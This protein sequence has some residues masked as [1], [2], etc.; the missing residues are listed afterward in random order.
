MTPSH[1]TEKKFEDHIEAHLLASG[2][3]KGKSGDYDREL[4]LIPAEVIAFVVATQPTEYEKLQKQYGDATDDN[5]CRRLAKEIGKRGTLDVLR[6]GFK[7]RGCSFRLSYFKPV[8]G[9]N[10]E[11]L[12]LYRQ[13]RFTVTRQPFYSTQNNNSIDV[14]LFLNGLPLITCELKNSLTGQFVE[15]AIKQYRKDRDP[16]EPFFKFKRCLVHFAVGNEKVAMTT[17]LAGNKT[18]F[19]PFNKDSENPVNPHGFRTHY[20]W[21]D[22]LQPDTLLDLL[23]NYLHVQTN[24]KK[25]Y[26]KSGKLEEKRSEALIFPRYHQ[27][28]VVRNLLAKVK[29]EGEGHSY[30]IQHSAGSGKSNSIAW[31]AH[32]LASLY[33]NQYDQQRLFDSIIVVTDRRVLDRQLQDTVKQFEQTTGV[34]V[35]IT[36]D[37]AA[38]RDAIEA[39]KDIIITTLQ[40]FGVISKTTSAHPGLRYAVIIDEAHSS[41]SGESAKHLNQTLNADLEH[42]EESDSVADEAT[43]EDK[44]LEEI[45]LRSKQQRHISYFAFTATPKNK[46]LELFGRKNFDGKPVAFH[47]YSMRQAIEE[48]FILDV[49]ENYT[50]FKRYFKLTKT[51]ASDK[52]FEKKKAI[53]LLTSYVDLQPHAIETKSRLMLDHFIDHTANAIEGRGRAMVVTRSRLHAVKYYL[54]FRKV[55]EEMNLSYKPLVAFSGEVIDPDTDARYTENGLNALPPKVG[56]P[57]ALKTPEFRILIAANKFQTGFDEPL[58]HTMYV[59]KKLGG[60]GAVQTL[61][62]LN[63]TMHGKDGCVVIDYVNEA[64]DILAGFQDYYQTTL[65]EDTTDPNKLYDLQQQ[66]VDF[67]L[68]LPKDVDAFATTFFDSKQPQEQLQPLLDAAR[69]LWRQ[70]EVDEREEFRGRLNQFSRLYGFLSQILTFEDVELEKFYVFCRLLARKLDRREGILP[71]EVLDAVDLDSFR[72][73]KTYEGT[74]DLRPED[75]ELP[76]IG[77]GSSGVN[78]D[79]TDLLSSIIKTLNETHG[80]NLSEDDR[81]DMQSLKDKVYRH[82][83]LRS[84]FQ[85]NNPASIRKMKF[86]EVLDDILLEFVHTKLD[87]YKKLNQPSVNRNLKDM[88]YSEYQ[89]GRETC[90]RPL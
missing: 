39:K 81:V 64:D 5:L 30:L 7:D 24:T 6:K 67:E 25:V 54:M 8:S 35:P 19:L 17:R 47:V 41:Q 46:T 51:A 61:S 29:N 34:V 52:E 18:R 83:D 37:S 15:E 44:I 50:T 22:I 1:P 43:L 53:R 12:A 23:E 10:P 79:E 76:T 31:L 88:W 58:L 80:L 9:M 62:R 63:R 33:R 65:L 14:A 16:K 13:N 40:K 11:H 69:D 59:D 77:E 71:L 84:V 57:D 27:F 49:L 4:C 55:M 70:R 48:K 82:D 42:A 66:I 90:L 72:I 78:E 85:A 60:V 21:E 68:F 2:Y 26:G 87:L 89:K 75:R 38:L 3:R 73:Q 20:L 32:Q 74:I 28:D 36:T 56:I 45:R 86:E